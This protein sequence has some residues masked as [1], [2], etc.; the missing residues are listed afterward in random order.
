MRRD[1]NR[2]NS[3]LGFEAEELSWDTCLE[4]LWV[5]PEHGTDTVNRIGEWSEKDL[6]QISLTGTEIPLDS[7]RSNM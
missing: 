7:T 1:E 4:T 3:F 5:L 6:A 2:E